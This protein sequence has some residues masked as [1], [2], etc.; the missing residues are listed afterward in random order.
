MRNGAPYFIDGVGGDASKELLKS[1]GGNSFRTWGSDTLSS[2]LDTA[3]KDG[4]TVAAGVWLGHKDQGFDY[5]KPDQITQQRI[6]IHDIIQQYRTHPALLI[7]SIGNEMEGDGSDPAVWREIEYLAKM[8]KQL[9]PHHPIMTVICEPIDKKIKELND[10]CPDVDI[11][12]I[13]AY[14]SSPTV[15]A[16]YLAVGGTKPFI[17]TEFGP[18]GQW[19]QPKTSWGASIELSSTAKAAWYL[20]AY[21]HSVKSRKLCLGSYA[22]LWGNKQEATATWYGIVLSS[23]EKLE[24][25]DILSALW[26]NRPYVQTAPVI[27]SL[28]IDGS[29]TVSPGT[30]MHVTL[31]AGDP[32]HKTLQYNWVVRADRKA[33]ENGGQAESALQS[34]PNTVLWTSASGADITAPNSPGTYR[35]FAYLRNTSNEAA[36]AN[37]PFLVAASTGTRGHIQAAKLPYNIYG[38]KGITSTDYIPSGYMGNSDAIKMDLLSKAVPGHSGG[39]CLQA[40]Y[41]ATDNWGGVVWQ[42]PINDWGDQPGGLN[43]TGAKKLIFWVRG[44]VGGEV[45]SF[46]YGLIGSDKPYHD[47]SNGKLTNVVLSTAWTQYTIDLTGKDLSDIKT[48]FAWTAAASGKLVTFYLD[49]IRYE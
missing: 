19:E 28:I 38:P 20:D 2:D 44:A 1:C 35:I 33:V 25:A 24:A 8:A 7:W 30:T 22:F 34:I 49:D 36:V 6:R 9:D 26:S 11:V 48:A 45:V 43:L 46:Q 21:I 4:L 39:I 15:A 12:G 47:S 37:I 17:L 5:T 23:G 16:R 27:N 10:N 14:G 13:N 31:N 41:N 29:S 18:P 3:Q 42:S 40:A 32:A